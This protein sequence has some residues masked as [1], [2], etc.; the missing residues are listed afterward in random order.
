ME[1]RLYR[2]RKERIVAG[3]AGGLGEYLGIDPVVVRLLFVLLALAT[4]WG[5]LLYIIL[6]II[7]HEAPVGAEPSGRMYRRLDARERGLL[8]GGTLVALG[9]VLLA[10]EIGLWWW[11]GLPRLWPLLL[12]AAGVALLID[13]VR[14]R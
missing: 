8:I 2:S 5:V 10:R 4:G 12:I 11:F 6:A 1:H 9:L 13:R 3:V 7:V 14:S